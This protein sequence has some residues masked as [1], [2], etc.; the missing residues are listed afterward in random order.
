MSRLLMTIFCALTVVIMT[1]GFGCRPA[2]RWNSDGDGDGDSDGDGDGD[3]DADIPC[4][5]LI[6][7]DGDTISDTHEGSDDFDLDG[8]PDYLDDDSDGDG[9][10]DRDE[11][12]DSDLCTPPADH[13]GDGWIDASDR[14]SDNDGLSDAEELTVYGTDRINP[15]SDGDGYTDLAEVAAGTDPNDASVG[16]PPDDFFVVLPYGGPEEVRDLQFNTDIEI[17]DVFFLVDTT[18]SMSSTING[19]ATS[20]ASVIVPGIQEAISNAWIGVGRFEDFPAG[21]YGSM[22]THAGTSVPGLPVDDIP[23]WLHSVM[24]DPN[25]PGE[26]AQIQQ[27]VEYLRDTG[28]GGD[29][30]ESHVEG[31]YQT[32]TGEGFDPWV[33]AQHCEMAPDDPVPPRGY[34]CFRAGALPIV[35]LVS[36]ATMHNGPGGFDSYSSSAVPGGGHTIDQAVEALNGIGARV[37][38]VA[39]NAWDPA[40]VTSHMQYVASAT[41]TVDAAGQPLVYQTGAEVTYDVVNAISDLAGGTPQDV[42][43]TNEDLADWPEYLERGEPEVDATQFIKSVVPVRALPEEGLLGEID[44]PAGTFRGVIPGTTVEF[45]IVFQNDFLPPRESSRIYE[46]LIVV[47]GNGVARLDERHVYIV[48]PP[49]GED[50]LI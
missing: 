10:S 26:M 48:V 39:S 1:V 5:R 34:P 8:T 2:N 44:V 7:T 45:Q 31:L 20:L 23:F 29:G 21:G 19:V 9:I 27:A 15:D 33:P 24:R 42:S 17:A 4:D 30:P 50:I 3:G 43:T 25:V 14:D 12:G 28:I 6:D 22:G 41:G 36:D 47:I 11:A 35:V 40:T 16:I 13:D 49:E 18:G 32:A 46:A 37:I 38:G